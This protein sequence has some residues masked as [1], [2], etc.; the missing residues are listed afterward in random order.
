MDDLS[1]RDVDTKAIAYTW[2][3]IRGG[4][5]HSARACMTGKCTNPGL[6][7]GSISRTSNI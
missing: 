4:G 7:L 6:A 5:T 3:P 1:V 2:W